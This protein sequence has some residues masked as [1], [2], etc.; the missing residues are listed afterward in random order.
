MTV[1]YEFQEGKVLL[2]EDRGWT[3]Y[4]HYGVDSGNIFY[5]TEGFMV[6][7]RR[8]FFQVYLGSKEE[9]GPGMRFSR[10]I[11]NRS[12]W[13]HQLKHH[14]AGFFE[15]VRTRQQP[16]APALQAH[17]SCA[18]T[19]LGEVAFRV[20]RVLEF[21]PE[22]ETVKNDPEANRLLTQGVPGTL[23]CLESDRPQIMTFP[24]CPGYPWLSRNARPTGPEAELRCRA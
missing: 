8:G 2:Y 12:W 11:G 15:S 5:G 20:R 7:S 4:G 23:E 10:R 21:D 13:S 9:L 24:D 6:F 1:A 17:L 18:L 16:S 22:T 19:H 3:P 14:L